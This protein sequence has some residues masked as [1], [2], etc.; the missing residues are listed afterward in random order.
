M[1]K[2]LGRAVTIY[3]GGVAIAAAREKTLDIQATPIDIT[4]AHPDGMQRFIDIV[5]SRSASVSIT[6]ITTDRTLYEMALSDDVEYTLTLDYGDS[7][8]TG[9]FMIAEYSDSAAHDGAAEFSASLVSH[10]VF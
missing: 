3:Y 9:Q 2:R 7:Q 10:G 1:S 5:S 8:F 4:D 6:G